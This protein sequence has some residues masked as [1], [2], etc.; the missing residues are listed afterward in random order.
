MMDLL[1]LHE[2][3]FRP[4]PGR[5]DPSFSFLWLSLPSGR[6]V[7]PALC[8]W[9]APTGIGFPERSGASVPVTVFP[10]LGDFLGEG[11]VNPLQYSCLENPMD[12]GAWKAAV[13][14]VAESDMTEWL[15]FH[16]SL[17]CTGEGNGNPLQCSYLENPRDGGAWWAAVYGVTQSQT[18]LKWL[19]SSSSSRED[20]GVLFPRT[21]T[22]EQEEVL[23]A[24]TP[25]A[26]APYNELF[27]LSCFSSSPCLPLLLSLLSWFLFVSPSMIVCIHHDSVLG[28][29]QMV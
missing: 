11:S 28:S 9:A 16:F 5:A 8:S 22:V 2:K 21:A 18:Q 20:D 1:H 7:G 25:L 13:H 19:S 17:S 26:P 14:G 3:F 29:L 23:V 10:E 12:R 6:G 4:L 24:L 15:H 27:S